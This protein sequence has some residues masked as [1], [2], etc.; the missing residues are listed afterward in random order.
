MDIINAPSPVEKKKKCTI[1]FELRSEKID[2]DGKVPV[3][4]IYQV[5]G[6]RKYYIQGKS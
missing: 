4:L 3:R 1:R 2:K 6:Q 5:K